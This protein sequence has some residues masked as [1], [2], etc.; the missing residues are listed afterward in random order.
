MRSIPGRPSRRR[1]SS[2]GTAV[3]LSLVL[4]CGPALAEA[5]PEPAPAISVT[6]TAAPPPASGGVNLITQAA[7]A[8][9]VLACA[10]RVDQVARFLTTGLV[11]SFWMFL[12]ATARDQHIVST[13][14]EIDS[15]GGPL[16]YAS[17]DFA[18]AMVDGCGAIYETVV[19]WPAKCAEVAAKQFT[20]LPKARNLGTQVTS[21][22]AGNGARVFLM[23]AGVAGCVSIKKELL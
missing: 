4:L 3:L 14:I 16:A 5:E 15:K 1:T 10:P 6:P 8:A 22:D 20:T 19:Y 9:G 13:S 11:G 21:L 2:A 7:V 12:P 17:A 23:P 18:P